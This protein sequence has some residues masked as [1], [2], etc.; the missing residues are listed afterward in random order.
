[1]TGEARQAAND[2]PEGYDAS[3]R[4]QA[5]EAERRSRQTLIPAVGP[6]GAEALAAGSVAVVGAGGLGSPVLTYLAAA[7]V[8]RLTVIDDDIVEPSNLGRQVLH[9]VGELG[10]PK[11]DSA[12]ARILS[13]APL[14]EVTTHRLRLTTAHADEVL[15]GH[16]AVID[17]TDNFATRFV[18]DDTCARHRIPLVWGAISG[19]IGT[20]SVFHLPPH[21]TALRDLFPEPPDPQRFTPPERAGAFGALCGQIGSTMAAEAVKIIVGTGAPLSGRVLHIDSWAGRFTEIPLR[22]RREP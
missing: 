22:S 17:A 19:V 11:V 14:C 5:D 2:G 10:R 3:S 16:D 18:L 1:M 9:G 13:L 7:G 4:A 20:V 15:P 21:D 8:G 12:R 6:A